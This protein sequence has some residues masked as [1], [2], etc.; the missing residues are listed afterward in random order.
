M[1]SSYTSVSGHLCEWMIKKK[2]SNKL[3]GV[4]GPY[5]LLSMGLRTANN[6]D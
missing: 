5:C 2:T 6:V 1:E 4:E 3:V